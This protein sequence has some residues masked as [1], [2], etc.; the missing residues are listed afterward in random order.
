MENE[1]KVN[2]KIDFKS[3]AFKKYFANTSWLLGEKIVRIIATFF[4]G[5]LLV[6]YLGPERFGI[7]SYSFSFIAIFSSIAILGIEKIVVK[8]I[9]NN[10]DERDSILGT[11]FF[12]RVMG[13]ILSFLLIFISILLT[14]DSGVTL[15]LIIAMSLVIAFRSFQVIDYYFQAKVIARYSVYSQLISLIIGSAIKLV[16][17]IISA[18]L[19]YFGIAVSF[20]IL[21]MALVLIRN[22]KLQGLK[23]F[24][25]NF[26]SEI[27]KN[28][29][30]E[31]W[32]L[33]FSGI[34]IT[35]YMKVDQIMLKQMLNEIEVGYYAAAVQLCES[36]YFLPMVISSSLFPAILKAKQTSENLYTS[37]MQKLIDLL[38]WIPFAMAIPVM[39]FSDLI[40]EL[41]YGNEFM[42]SS[43]V[44]T[45]YI[46]AS[47]AA[48]LNVATGQYLVA[49][50]LTR[51]TLI[52]NLIGLVLNIILNL[53]FIPKYGIIGS[54]YATLISYFTAALSVGFFR[55]S[56]I[57]FWMMIKS[58][59][60]ITLYHHLV[61]Y[62]KRR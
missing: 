29:F 33:I 57:L 30:S 1:N 50:K 45:I 32:P 2:T 42:S 43:A 55:N 26:N 22:Y 51:I 5:I 38:A 40:V 35:I 6:R 14:G 25:W 34:A 58:L 15:F 24:D 16:L 18:P 41:L 23:L 39:I 53:I 11:A 3:E 56:R 44:L 62:L 9:V 46:W 31:S 60:F 47:I 10:P 8:E 7:F 36:W 54:A 49:E 21:I 37:S 61:S 20:E 17:I 59:F 28:I 52:R 4:V 27:A 12:F 48:F 19:L 13:T